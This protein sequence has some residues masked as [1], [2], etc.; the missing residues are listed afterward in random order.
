[1]VPEASTIIVT[2]DPGAEFIFRSIDLR[3]GRSEQNRSF[4]IAN[5]RNFRSLTAV[6]LARTNPC[7]VRASVSQQFDAASRAAR[8]IFCT[9][10]ESNQ[11]PS[12]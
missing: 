4:A 12:D 1:V 2:V 10:L 5:L 6:T 11:Q 9:A 7:L 8:A 3:D